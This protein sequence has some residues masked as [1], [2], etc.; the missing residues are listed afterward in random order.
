MLSRFDFVMRSLS[1]ND[2]YL[3]R[4]Y[5]HA[6]LLLSLELLSGGRLYIFGTLVSDCHLD[7][8]KSSLTLVMLAGQKIIQKNEQF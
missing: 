1:V 7:L 6:D 3:Q 2:A 8:Y 5:N 4:R